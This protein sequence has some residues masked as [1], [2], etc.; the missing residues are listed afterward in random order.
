M[1]FLR[2]AA[3]AVSHRRVLANLIH[4][5]NALNHHAE[6]GI[7]TPTSDHERTKL[8][9]ETTELLAIINGYSGKEGLEEAA[10][11]MVELLKEYASATEIQIITF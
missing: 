8:G 1:I 7:V 11:Y 9:L 2:H 6:G 4:N 3:V 5:L 10:A